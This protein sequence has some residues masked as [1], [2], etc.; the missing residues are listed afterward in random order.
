MGKEGERY[1]RQR[2]LRIAHNKAIMEDLGLPTIATPLMVSIG[3]K[4]QKRV[5]END[6]EDVDYE[7]ENH[8]DDTDNDL[9]SGYTHEP[10]KVNL[11]K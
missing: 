4:K 5:V 9:D 3:K 1:E 10:Q 11:T 6:K 8:D 7:P 2:E